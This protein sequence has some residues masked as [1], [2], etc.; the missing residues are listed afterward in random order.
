[1]NNDL[2]LGHAAFWDE[3]GS[4]KGIFS[5]VKGHNSSV[6]IKYSARAETYHG[7]EYEARYFMDYRCL[8]TDSIW[9]VTAQLKLTTTDAGGATERDAS[10]NL[11]QTK[12]YKGA[13]PSIRVYLYHMVANSDGEMEKKTL[14]NKRLYDYNVSTW[15]AAGFNPFRAQFTVPPVADVVDAKVV[16]RDFNATWNVIVDDV[17]VHK[18]GA[19]SGSAVRL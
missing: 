14:L 2:E 9:E 6:A 19:S 18:I 12:T 13:C 15:N 10:C 17:S 7:P 11:D 8:T 4:P 5:N 16:V 3:Y 1:M